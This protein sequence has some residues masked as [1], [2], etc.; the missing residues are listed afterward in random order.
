MKTNKDKRLGAERVI[1][2]W[3]ESLIDENFCE[4]GHPKPCPCYVKECD[5]GYPIDSGGCSRGC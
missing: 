4:C 1:V 2:K 5:C 3:L